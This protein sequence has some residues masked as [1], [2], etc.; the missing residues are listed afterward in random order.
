MADSLTSRQVRGDRPDPAGPG[1]GEPARLP[2]PRHGQRAARTERGQQV[3]DLAGRLRGHGRPVRD[4][5]GSAGDQRRGEERHGIGKIGLNDHLVVPDHPRVNAPRVGRA[6]RRIRL[7]GPRLH[8]GARVAEHADRH[9]DVRRGRGPAAAVAYLRALVEPRRGDQQAGHELG[10]GRGVQGDRAARQRP[11]PMHGERDAAPPAVVDDGTEFAQCGEYRP[12]RPL[13]R[14]GIAVEDGAHAGQGRHGRGEPQHR[15]GV[16]HVHGDVGPWLPRSHVPRGWLTGRACIVRHAVCDRGAE[17]GQRRA[18]QQ[19]VAGVQRAGDGP[20]P[21]GER[22]EHQGP[23]CHGFRARHGAPARAPGRPRPG[24]ARS[25]PP[26][27]PC[28]P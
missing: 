21:V 18:H 16:T 10:G 25:V 6:W 24:R 1:H 28:A 11:G 7:P 20:R 23:V 17:G 15:A 22:G 13:R 27:V 9:G 8:L 3:E 2:F 12:H 26:A 19:R 4:R 5:H 14:P